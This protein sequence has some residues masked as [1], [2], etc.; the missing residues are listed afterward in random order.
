MR[1]V[2]QGVGCSKVP[3]INDVGLMEDRAT[4]RISSQHIA[5]WLHHGIVTREQVMDVM[6]RM[7][8]VVDRQ[9]AGDPLY[10]PMAPGFDGEAFKA[11]C[12]LVFEGAQQPSGYTEPLLHQYRLLAKQR[13]LR[14]RSPLPLAGE[15]GAQRRVRRARSAGEGVVHRA[16][17]RCSLALMV[18]RA[19]WLVRRS[20]T[21]HGEPRSRGHEASVALILQNEFRRL[22][23]ALERRRSTN[24][25]HEHQ[26]RARCAASTR[27]PASLPT[28]T[29]EGYFPSH[30]AT[31]SGRS[32]DTRDLNCG[33]RFSRNART[34]SAPSPWLRCHIASESTRCASSGWL[35]ATLR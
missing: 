5:N 4:C 17:G 18:S 7:A 23:T 14:P 13:G 20:R 34:P 11:A 19:S 25:A 15:V 6:R 27:P 21:S 30:S 10:R 12:D 2:D 33:G 32:V 16:R 31:K 26:P 8:A 24:R 29:G 9:N 1:W 3:D 35:A 22:A 28:T